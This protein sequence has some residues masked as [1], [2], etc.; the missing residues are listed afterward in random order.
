MLASC[1]T[2]RLA[3]CRSLV[4]FVFAFLFKKKI[5]V[6]FLLIVCERESDSISSNGA[7]VRRAARVARLRVAICDQHSVVA[8]RRR[9]IGRRVG[10]ERALRNRQVRRLRVNASAAARRHRIGAIERG[11]RRVHGALDVH[12]AARRR[13]L[14]DRVVRE[15]G[16]DRRGGRR[17]QHA[18]RRATSLARERRLSDRRLRLTVETRENKP[19]MNCVSKL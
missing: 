7:S 4:I 11:R 8:R 9:R 13:R 16:A 14:C 19:V 3:E 18:E 12:S 17:R 5:R 2:A 1:S 10:I 15:L 6:K